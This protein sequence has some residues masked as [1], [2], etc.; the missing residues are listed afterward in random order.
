MEQDLINEEFIKEEHIQLIERAM[1]LHEESK[2]IEQE[3]TPEELQELW[4]GLKNLVNKG[5][6]SIKN[7]AKNTGKAIANKANNVATAVGNATYDAT[8][9]AAKKAGAAVA[10]AATN[11]KD[12]VADTYNQGEIDAI[13]QKMHAL[14]NKYKA[15]TGKSFVRQFSAASKAIPNAQKRAS[16]QPNTAAQ[17]AMAECAYMQRLAGLLND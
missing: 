8:I 15:L 11:V 6:S 1:L 9:G 2:S 10:T 4:G 7:T 17:M 5:Y 14:N 12:K 3:M 13:V 16:A